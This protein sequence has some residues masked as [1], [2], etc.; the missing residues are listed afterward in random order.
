MLDA[1][2]ASADGKLA[3]RVNGLATE[4]DSY[5]DGREAARCARST[6]RSPGGPTRTRASRLNFEYVQSDFAP[7]QRPPARERRDRGRA[8]HALVPVAVRRLRPG[9]LPAAPRRGAPALGPRQSARQDL[10]HRLKWDSEGTLIVGA[11]PIP[12]F[13]TVVARTLPLLDDRQKWLGNQL[14]LT[15]RLHHRQRAAHAA[16]RASRSAALTDEFTLDVALLPVIDLFQ[17]GR[18]GAAAAVPDPR[19]VA[20]GRRAHAVVAPYVMDRIDLGTRRRSW[21]ARGSTRSRLRGGARPHRARRHQGEPAAG[22]VVVRSPRAACRS[23]RARVRRSARPPAW[24][25]ASASPRRAGSSRSGVKKTFLGGKAFADRGRLPP[26]EG[27]HRHPG[28]HGRHAPDGRPALARL[29]AGAAGRGAAGLVRDRRRTR[30]R[31]R[32]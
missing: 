16:R 7:G 17:P 11:F 12:G 30:S 4:T 13:A 31:T 25:S 27:Q 15:A 26:G 1:N 18:D 24:W 29:R 21:P 6:R 19:P 3:F 14:E 23:T 10:L 9:R 28:R 22:G 8:A 20:G 5:R 32:S 2:A